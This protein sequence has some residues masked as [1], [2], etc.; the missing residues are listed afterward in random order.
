[1]RHGFLGRSSQT[2][3]STSNRG[4]KIKKIEFM[5]VEWGGFRGKIAFFETLALHRLHY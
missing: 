2:Q 4:L 3:R 1:M 5:C